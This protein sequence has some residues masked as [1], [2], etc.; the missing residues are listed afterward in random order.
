MHGDELTEGYLSIQLDHREFVSGL[1]SPNSSAPPALLRPDA[2]DVDD[3]VSDDGGCDG[4]SSRLSTPAVADASA[5]DSVDTD[6][7]TLQDTGTAPADRYVS[8][9]VMDGSLR[10]SHEVDRRR[11]SCFDHVVWNLD[12]EAE[13]A[14]KVDILQ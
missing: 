3:G 4:S 7:G 14:R 1:F 11:K 8:I 6:E 10:Q 9:F 5:S 13:L 2:D 12:C